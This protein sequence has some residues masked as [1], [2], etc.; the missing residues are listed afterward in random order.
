[1]ASGR[2][3]VGKRL[4]LAMPQDAAV[5][6]AATGGLLSGRRWGETPERPLR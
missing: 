6:T 2:S 1:M 3:I 5:G 4:T